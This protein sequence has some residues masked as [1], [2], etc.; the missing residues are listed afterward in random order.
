MAPEQFHLFRLGRTRMKRGFMAPSATALLLLSVCLHSTDC[1]GG[2]MLLSSRKLG[3][4]P[5]TAAACTVLRSRGGEG[6]CAVRLRLKGGGDDTH[7]QQ[8][9]DSD[10]AD[11]A[12]AEAV[13]KALKKLSFSPPRPPPPPPEPPRVAKTI[14]EYYQDEI[15]KISNEALQQPA[16]EVGNPPPLAST[17]RAPSVG[18]F[19]HGASRPMADADARDLDP[20][21]ELQRR[22]QQ[23]ALAAAAAAAAASPVQVAQWT[24]EEASREQPPSVPTPAPMAPQAVPVKP[25]ELGSIHARTARVNLGVLV[26]PC[27]RLEICLLARDVVF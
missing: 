3:K 14:D 8:Q 9:H 2:R 12:H 20:V 7:G 16:A 18:V 19:R 27:V 25:G 22:Q 21:Q 1:R 15:Y 24:V 26:L 6:P 17:S 13:D 11:A 23:E 5:G 10:N 4:S